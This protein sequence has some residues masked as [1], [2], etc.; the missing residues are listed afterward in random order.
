MRIVTASTRAGRF[1]FLYLLAFMI[2]GF[3]TVMAFT[4]LSA[5]PPDAV[6]GVAALLIL[7]ALGCI[8]YLERV[9]PRDP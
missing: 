9:L 8:L 5:T 3:V 2:G 6:L 4:F 1:A 7:G